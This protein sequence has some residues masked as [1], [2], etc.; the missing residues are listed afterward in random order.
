MARDAIMDIMGWMMAP[1]EI[2][3]CPNPKNMW[4]RL[5]L[6]RQISA[7]IMSSFKMRSFQMI[8]VD[9]TARRAHK[10]QRLRRQT[11]WSRPHEERGRCAAKG[12]RTPRDTRNRERQWQMLLWTVWSNHYPTDT[13]I[14]NFQPP[15]HWENTFLLF[16]SLWQFLTAAIGNQHRWDS[17]MGKEVGLD[18]RFSSF[19]RFRSHSSNGRLLIK[20]RNFSCSSWR[21][22]PESTLRSL[23]S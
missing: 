21:K 7:D 2:C 10:A 11:Q 16:L 18:P 22:R 12:L 8:G 19:L 23:G 17:C 3:L 5:Y 4:L 15:E 20:Q 13:L 9:T 14:L 1:Q 6:E